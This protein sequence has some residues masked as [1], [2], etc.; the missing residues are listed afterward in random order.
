MEIL[1]NQIDKNHPDLP[2]ILSALNQAQEL[3]KSGKA[4][5]GIECV[6]E[7]GLEIDNQLFALHLAKKHFQKL[8]MREESLLFQELFHELLNTNKVVR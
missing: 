1:L 5:A 6:K 7:L 3:F 2:I 4:D 8:K